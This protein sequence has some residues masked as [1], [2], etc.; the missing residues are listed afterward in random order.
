MNQA[1]QFPDREEWRT[2]ISAVVF[3]GVGPW[4]AVNMRYI[5]GDVGVPL[6]RLHA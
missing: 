3:P 1:I 4:Y 5:R 2:D 6:W